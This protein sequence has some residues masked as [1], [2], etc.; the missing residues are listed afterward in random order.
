MLLMFRR[1]R[2]GSFYLYKTF[3]ADWLLATSSGV[4]V[5]R[6]VEKADGAF[7]RILV[8][9]DLDGLAVDEWIWR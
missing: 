8:K 7:G 3:R 9:I 6:I 2:V 1:V 4:K 5:G